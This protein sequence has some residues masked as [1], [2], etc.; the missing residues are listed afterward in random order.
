MRIDWLKLP[1]FRNLRE[2]EIDFDESQPTT[3]VLGRNGSG[4]S[5][6]IEAL[7]EIFRDLEEQKTSAFPYEI[8]YLC[9]GHTIEVTN[10]PGSKKGQ[11]YS[12]DGSWLSRAEFAA[13][14]DEVLPQHVFAYYSGWNRRLESGFDDPTRKLYKKWLD[15]ED[16][17]IPLR[18]LF[19]CRKEYSQLVLLAFFLSRAK[20]TQELLRKYLNIEKF[21]SALFIF[22]TPWWRGSGRPNKLQKETGDPRFWY[23]R[24]AFKHFLDRLW[25]NALAPIANSETVERDVRGRR[26][27]TER[28]YLYIKDQKQLK[29][30]AGDDEPKEFFG[31]LE[32]LFLC[33]LIDEVR[34][35]V[36][37]RTAGKIRFEQLSEGEQQLLT[38]LGLMLFTQHEESLFL[39]DEPDTHLNPSW[40]YEYYDLLKEYLPKK[41]SQLLI[42]T[43][44]PLM[45]GGLRKNQVRLL[46]EE[47]VEEGK[48]STAAREPE[49]DPIGMG[50]DGLLTSEIYG[51][52]SVLPTEILGKIDARNELFALKKRSKAQEE[53][54]RRLSDELAQ[55]GMLRSYLDPYEQAFVKAMA[56][57]QLPMDKSLSPEEI[58]ARNQQADEVLEKI[59][60]EESA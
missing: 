49:E 17:D 12:V 26:E 34:I 14:H 27:S 43:H 7:V 60:K 5:N 56:R 1:R 31:L 47:E 35:T 42:A 11:Q 32:S 33:D 51:L 10:E 13:L 30:L 58:Q 38:V 45:I 48:T 6:L 36:E 24:G 21:D 44:N 53:E 54:L 55:L 2:F 25:K 23:A 9:H 15:N 40:I 39:L 46:V 52:S 41:S 3:V 22:K 37:H 19:Y 50:V 8:K 4:K 18:R 16:R 59:F 28:L 57:R 29:A 20:G